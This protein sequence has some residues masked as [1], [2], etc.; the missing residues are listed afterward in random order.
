MFLFHYYEVLL[1]AVRIIPLRH[2]QFMIFGVSQRAHKSTLQ[3]GK[4][5]PGSFPIQI[6]TNSNNH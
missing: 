6:V 1:L 5:R 3:L 4:S 2:L